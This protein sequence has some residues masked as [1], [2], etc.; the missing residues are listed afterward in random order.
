[1]VFKDLCSTQIAKQ[2]QLKMKVRKKRMILMAGAVMVCLM[3]GL[4]SAV[5]VAAC[6]LLM[7]MGRKL[8]HDGA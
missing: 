1:M 6:R 8:T 2:T 4:T 5:P 3:M 7:P